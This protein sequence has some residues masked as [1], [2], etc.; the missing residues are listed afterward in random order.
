MSIWE[1]AGQTFRR[2]PDRAGVQQSADPDGHGYGGSSTGDRVPRNEPMA[3]DPNDVHVGEAVRRA[4]DRRVKDE[5]IRHLD[6]IELDDEAVDGRIEP[7]Y[8]V[9]ESP[10]GLRSR[11]RAVFRERR[12]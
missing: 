10:Q 8:P 7:L 6:S 2:G 11:L 12:P 9:R 4:A 3:V 5:A 1:A